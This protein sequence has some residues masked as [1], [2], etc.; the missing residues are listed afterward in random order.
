MQD[1][2]I[3]NP[4][5][6]QVRRKSYCESCGKAMVTTRF[7]GPSKCHPCRRVARKDKPSRTTAVARELTCPICG[8][9]FTAHYRLK[10]YCSKKCSR[11]NSRKRNS[12]IDCGTTVAD[13]KSTRC[14][15]CF[16]YEVLGWS[17]CTDL[18]VIPKPER[19]WGT[20]S[21]HE[22]PHRKGWALVAGPC[23]WCGN[24]FIG[25]PLSVYCQKRCA[26]NAAW[27]RKD[28]TRGT[29]APT[30]RL[31]QFICERD[32]WTCQLCGDPVDPDAQYNTGGYATLDHIIPQS[33]QLIPDH[34]ASNLRLS[35]M[36]C[37]AR[38]GNRMEDLALTA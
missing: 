38:R 28:D 9:N 10:T 7:D 35:H 19:E 4:K 31:R 14:M 2:S 18:A 30:P 27:K 29:F 11:V 33:L 23:G 13:D 5:P 25:P 37:N 15:E 1:S 8:T 36:I 12:C 17:R 34:S 16:R 6:K 22:L 24:N 21:T 32:K 20:P 26:A 3:N